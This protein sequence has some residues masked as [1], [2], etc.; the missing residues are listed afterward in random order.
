MVVLPSITECMHE[1]RNI[2][3]YDKKVF[4]K[5][6]SIVSN[7]TQEVDIGS[8]GHTSHDNHT[9]YTGYASHTANANQENNVYDISVQV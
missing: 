8:A 3:I 1:R 6:E 5:N 4:S 2:A 9:G 7:H